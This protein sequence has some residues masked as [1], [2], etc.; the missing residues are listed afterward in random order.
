MTCTLLGR[1]PLQRRMRLDSLTA[2][3]ALLLEVPSLPALHLLAKLQG[4]QSS[5][6]LVLS[7]DYGATVDST[8]LRLRNPRLGQRGEG[9]GPR[10]LRG[11]LFVP[12]RCLRD[13]AP[14]RPQRG[15]LLPGEGPPP[16]KKMTL[17]FPEVASGPAF[18]PRKEADM[19]RRREA[20]GSPR[21]VRDPAGLRRGPVDAED[22]PRVPGAGGRRGEE[23]LRHVARVHGR[24]QHVE[25]RDARHASG[26]HHRR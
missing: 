15:A 8:N 22:G 18:L 6:S 16:G 1:W 12:L 10:P 13:A 7:V 24:L 2:A 14:R 9:S 26:V 23:V 5:A 3:Q 17:H 20:S 25:P 21:Q 11:L 4:C 19:I